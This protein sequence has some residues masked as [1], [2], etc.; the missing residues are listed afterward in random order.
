MPCPKKLRVNPFWKSCI[1]KLQ[2]TCTML[3]KLTL[4]VVTCDDE[5]AIGREERSIFPTLAEGK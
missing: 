5:D 4:G 1:Y 3:V 2:A